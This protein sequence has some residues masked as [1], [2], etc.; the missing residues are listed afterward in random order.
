MESETVSLTEISSTSGGQGANLYLETRLK[1]EGKEGF[2]LTILDGEI[3]WEGTISEDDLDELCAKVRMDFDTYVKETKAAFTQ[4]NVSKQSFECH[5]KSTAMSAQL[6]WKK[7]LAVDV[8]FHL[9]SVTLKKCPT[10]AVTVCQILSQCIARSQALQAKVQS[11]ESD[12]ERLSIERQNA[13]KR[14]DKC[15]T[16]KDQLEKD[17]YSKFVLVLN[18]KKQR[19]RELKEQ[20]QSVET[21]QGPQA[22][23][24]V[25]E[26]SQPA[27]RKTA[28]GRNGETSRQTSDS[29]SDGN[30]VDTEEEVGSSKKSKMAASSKNNTVGESFLNLNEDEEESKLAPVARRPQRQKATKKQTPVKPT[31]P[32]LSSGDAQERPSSAAKRSSTRR[33]ASQ[34]SHQLPD[35]LDPDDLI[36]NF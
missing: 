22:S 18:S 31:L 13:L 19:I 9:G 16:A 15:V 34:G 7:I 27:T 29:Q 33:S 17:L 6:S 26:N 24:A 21:G 11:L 4:E 14:L 35:I 30:D 20:L 2:I 12:N 28:R 1:N 8:K 36:N 25:Q 10:S 5:F 23:Q 32:R 3:V